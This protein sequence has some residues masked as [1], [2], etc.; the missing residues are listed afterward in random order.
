MSQ[1]RLK[2]CLS[3]TLAVAKTKA[4][5]MMDQAGIFSAFACYDMLQQCS[6]AE[7][8]QQVM[9]LVEKAK[10]QAARLSCCK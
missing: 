7:V 4:A 5:P 2:P 1:P 6:H 9:Q 8:K 10:A 3:D